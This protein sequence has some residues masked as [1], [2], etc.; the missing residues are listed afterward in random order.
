MKKRIRH[1]YKWDKER[2]DNLNYDK[3]NIIT[4]SFLAEEFPND[5]PLEAVK[6]KTAGFYVNYHI[7][8]PINCTN[9]L[10]MERI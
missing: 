8:L 1:N 7:D 3:K 9:E 5:E 6:N 2:L 10:S 4:K